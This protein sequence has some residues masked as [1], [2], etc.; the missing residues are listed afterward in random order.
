VVV[1]AILVRV[2]GPTFFRERAVYIVLQ[3]PGAPGPREVRLPAIGAPEPSEGPPQAGAER[4]PPVGLD[5]TVETLDSIPLA[6]PDTFV[7]FAPGVPGGEGEPGDSA[8]GMGT[9]RWIGPDYAGGR[10]W[11]RPWQAEL[12]VVGPSEN[13]TVHVARIDAAIRERIKAFIDTMPRDSF[14]LPPPPVWTAEVDGQTWG[15]DERW[16]YLGDLKI[17]SAVLALLPLPQGNIDRAREATDL[18]RIRE[19]IIRA[20]R[21]AADAKEFR[22]YVDELRKR[23]DEERAR[24]RA[25]RDTVIPD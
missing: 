8:E 21:R 14:A 10:L 6:A 2:A 1:A 13:V 25:K 5:V 22:K 18:L 23:K 9:Q 12:G 24:E 3:D 16:I 11:I 19:D 7:V 20:A 17:P 4:A 15:I